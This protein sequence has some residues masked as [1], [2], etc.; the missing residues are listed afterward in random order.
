MLIRSQDH[1]GEAANPDSSN[2]APSRGVGQRLA[3]IDDSTSVI[4]VIGGIRL[5]IWVVHLMRGPADR[6]S[7]RA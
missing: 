6:R 5:L 3:Y 1:L 2:P 7:E 4:D